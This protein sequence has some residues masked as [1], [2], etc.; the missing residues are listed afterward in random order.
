MKWLE[1]FV[2]FVDASNE[3]ICRVV[4]WGIIF[5]MCITVFN[6]LMRYAFDAPTTWAYTLGGLL[7]GPL[8]LLAGGYTLA[9]GGHVR[10]DVLYRRLSPRKQAILDLVTFL[11]FFFYCFLI[12]RFGIDYFWLSFTRQDHNQGVWKPVLWPFKLTLPVGMGL[13]LLAGIAKYIRDIYVAVTGRSL[14]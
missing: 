3:R 8:W 10:M 6:V 14:K 7:L 4:S 9:Q 13:I 12:F 1:S 5:I 2:R 11:L